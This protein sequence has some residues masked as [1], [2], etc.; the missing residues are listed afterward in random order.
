MAISIFCPYCKRHT[1]LS[2]APA[3]YTDAFRNEYNT[4]A[5]WE[6]R[7]GEKWWIGICNNCHN[8]VLVKNDGIEIHPRPFPSP[9]DER[10]PEPMR[11]DLIEAK[12]C[13]SIDAYRACAVRVQ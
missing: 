8:P 6:K 5:I 10:I 12:L 2:I 9:T 3:L 1:A 4:A 11:Q 13:F 7:A